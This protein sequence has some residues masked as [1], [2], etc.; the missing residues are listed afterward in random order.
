VGPSDVLDA[1]V[2]YVKSCELS[3]LFERTCRCDACSIP[4][5]PE[6]LTQRPGVA[7]SI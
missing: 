2:I 6:L 7:Q 1:V 5:T 3:D 4:V